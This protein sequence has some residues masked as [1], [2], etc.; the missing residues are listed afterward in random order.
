VKRIICCLFVCTVAGP[1]L[2]AETRYGRAASLN[3]LMEDLVSGQTMRLTIDPVPSPR[4]FMGFYRIS[5]P[6]DA[7]ELELRLLVQ[8]PGVTRNLYTQYNTDVTLEDGKGIITYGSEGPTTEKVIL[9]TPAS[10]PPLQP[11]YHAQHHLPNPLERAP[12][13]PRC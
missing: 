4:L 6:A 2:N 5:V 8:T 13:P 3:R 12:P 10:K 1:P 11:G 9:V 7:T